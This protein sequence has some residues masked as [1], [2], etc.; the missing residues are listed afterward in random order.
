LWSVHDF[1][2]Y[3]IFIGW[4]IHRELTYPICGSDTYCFHL[5]HGGKINY[6][7]CYRCW[8]PQKHKFRQ[9][10]NTFKKDNIITKGLLKH[11]SGPQIIDM[12]NKL[13][14]DPKRHG[15]FVGYGETH[16]WTHKY[17]LWKLPYIPTLILMYN[18]DVMQ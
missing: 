4:S 10:Q 8:L 17:A 1:K 14:P 6:F 9:Q 13:M 11:L 2:A 16:N 12:L 7:N 3:D 5:T 15:Y 18:I